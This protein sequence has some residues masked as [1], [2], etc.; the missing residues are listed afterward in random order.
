V[1]DDERVTRANRIHTCAECGCSIGVGETYKRV[2][3]GG[4]V[5]RA[6]YPRC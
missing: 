1:R 3:G 2:A 6:H 5:Y 4:M